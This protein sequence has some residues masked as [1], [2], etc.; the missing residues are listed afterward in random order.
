MDRGRSEALMF[1]SLDCAA[2]A[3]VTHHPQ[4]LLIDSW[5]RFFFTSVGIIFVTPQVLSAIVERVPPPPR[6]V[7]PAAPLRARLVDSWFDSIRWVGREGGREGGWVGGWMDRLVCGW[8][9]PS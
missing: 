1:E 9:R 2:P 7:N 6:E 8:M 3:R 5:I 4:P